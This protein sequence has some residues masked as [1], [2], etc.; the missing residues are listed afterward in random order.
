M[1]QAAYRTTS[2]SALRRGSSLGSLELGHLLG[3]GLEE[4][5]GRGGLEAEHLGV[6]LGSRDLGRR[7]GGG[8]DLLGLGLDHLLLR[9]LGDHGGQG[10]VE[11]VH[12]L[13]HREPG[14][15]DLLLHVA[16]GAGVRDLRDGDRALE[17]A[18]VN[19]ADGLRVRDVHLVALGAEDL[20]EPGLG[21]ELEAELLHDGQCLG[22]GHPGRGLGNGG[23]LDGGGGGGLVGGGHCVYLSCCV[24][25]NCS[26]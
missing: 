3:L 11:V 12:L 24:V 13:L 8:G 2:C 5:L 4:L 7:G 21:L 23:G 19:A 6:H 25:V 16:E 1:F 9:G 26:T 22:D 17:P 20:D 10:R 18:D 15:A 14:Q